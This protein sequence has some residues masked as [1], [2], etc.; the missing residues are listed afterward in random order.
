MAWLFCELIEQKK[1]KGNTEKKGTKKRRG[2]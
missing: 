1:E 2:K